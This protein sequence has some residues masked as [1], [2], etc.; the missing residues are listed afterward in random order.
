MKLNKKLM[1]FAVAGALGT[2]TAT[3]AMA[4]ENEFHGSYKAFGFM[5]NAFSGGSSFQLREKSTTDKFIEQRARLQY[6]AK[7]SDD[8]KLVTHFELDTKFGGSSSAKYP[9]GDGGGLDADRITLET[10]SVYLDFKIPAVPVRATVGVQPFNDSFGGLYGNFDATGVVFTGKFGA[11]T[12]TYGY[13]TV[14][15]DNVNFD[16]K[17]GGKVLST[18]TS[19]VAFASN[20]GTKDLNVLDAKFAINKDITVGASYYMLL[21]KIV[22]GGN[23]P[24]VVNNTLGLNTAAKI[25]PASLTAA[26]GFQFGKENNNLAMSAKSTTAIAAAVAAKVAAGPG[27]V[28]VAALYLSGDNNGTGYNKAW[29]SIDTGVNFYSPANMWLITRNSA[30]INSATAIGTK[31][32]TRGGLGL[33]GAFAG[34]AGTAGKTFYNANVGYAKV[35]MKRAAESATVGTELNATIGYKLYDNLSTQLTAAYAFLGDGY[36]KDTG[37]LITTPGGSNGV[38][39]ADNPF[40]T[41]IVLSYAF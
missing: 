5:T 20:A 16:Y 29:Q 11:L 38:A 41:A 39:K 6:I 25:G 4:F 24:T 12:T 30:M 31:D 14:G 36:G 15:S 18:A 40:M 32:L 10:K 1:I 22:N 35:A 28:N 8:L 33:V 27:S 19:G 13:F 21:D 26:L 17:A 9:Q 37:T 2:V 3:S 34:Y 7:A 23:S